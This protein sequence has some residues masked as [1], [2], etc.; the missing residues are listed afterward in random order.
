MIR[1]DDVLTTEPTCLFPVKTFRKHRFCLA[2]LQQPAAVTA[3][4]A[5]EPSK[6]LPLILISWRQASFQAF[7]SAYGLVIGTLREKPSHGE[8]NHPEIVA[9]PW[10]GQ[11]RKHLR[12]ILPFSPFSSFKIS[13]FAPRAAPLFILCLLRSCSQLLFFFFVFSRRC[14]SGHF[15][16]L[17]G[18]AS[19]TAL[20]FK[21]RYVTRNCKSPRLLYYTR[22]TV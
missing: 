9:S 4:A 17:F 19:E 1:A 12:V 20:P 14:R 10:K 11:S 16:K 15:T 21:T 2:C 5:L 8:N 13:T 6:P 22:A 3:A 7:Q 18:V